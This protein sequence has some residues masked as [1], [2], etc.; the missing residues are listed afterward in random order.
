MIRS[1]STFTREMKERP[2]PGYSLHG[3]LAHAGAVGDLLDR[4]LIGGV[5]CVPPS[6]RSSWLR[7]KKEKPVDLSGVDLD[8]IDDELFG[9]HL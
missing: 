5:A 7:D 2:V 4:D 1:D 6:L 3:F 8:A 9:S